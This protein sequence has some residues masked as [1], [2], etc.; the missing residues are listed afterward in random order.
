MTA[1]VV[2]S[3]AVEGTVDEVALRRIC[4][5]LGAGLG[6]VYGRKGKGFVLDRL[7]GYNNSA[8][9]RHWVVLV[10]LDND[11]PCAPDAVRGW[12]EAPAELMCFRVAVREIESWL[13]ADR[14]RL[15]AFLD[16]RQDL[17][18]EDPDGLADPK[19]ALIELARSSGNR[20]IRDDIVPDPSAGG[21]EGPGYTGRMIEF[22]TCDD[23]SWRP[24]VAASASPSLRK[25]LA[26]VAELVQK[27]YPPARN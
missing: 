16:V 6:D 15:A 19:R 27:P 10:D 11:F 2:V 22:I 23:R 1:G 8:R 18:P 7:P 12:L 5:L 14:E 21:S 13:M 17:V 26:S 4:S 9:H 3:A 20:D 24:D 25:C